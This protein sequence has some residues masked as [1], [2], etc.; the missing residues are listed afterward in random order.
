MRVVVVTHRRRR[1]APPFC[2]S[3]STAARGREVVARIQRR[4]S[5]PVDGGVAPGNAVF[6]QGEQAAQR[7]VVGARA[8]HD[9]QVPV[10]REERVLAEIGRQ[11]RVHVAPASSDSQD[12]IGARATRPPPNSTTR[13]S[14]VS[15]RVV[16]VI[17]SGEVAVPVF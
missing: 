8:S 3:S 5:R 14:S 16:Q 17:P 4:R 9:E 12:A 11:S 2:R 6:A 7:A 13:V 10:G 1:P 15:Q